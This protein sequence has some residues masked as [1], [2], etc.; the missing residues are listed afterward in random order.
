M[1][2]LHPPKPVVEKIRVVIIP[3]GQMKK[4]IFHRELLT[5]FEV[6]YWQGKTRG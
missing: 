6:G 4:N 2:N 3:R 5:I 1:R